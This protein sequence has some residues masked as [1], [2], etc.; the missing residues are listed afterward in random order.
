V[1]YSV[2]IPALDE[3]RLVAAAVASVLR[4]G[5][6]EVIVVDGASD[7]DTCA[8]AARAGARVV[9]SRAGRGIQL[10]HGA[11][12]AT[13][14]WL[15]FLHADTR[16]EAGWEQ[17]LERL[18]A[19]V[20]GGA[21][22]LAVDSRRWRYRLVEAGV[23]ARCRLFRTP[24]GDQGIFVRRHLYA[25]CGGFPPWPLMED[26]VFVRRLR[27]LGRLAFPT[28]RAFTSPRRAESGGFVAT[29]LQNWWLMALFA[30]GRSPVDLAKRYRR[31]P[32]AG[33]NEPQPP[34]SRR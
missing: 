3:Q 19:D 15:V 11:R 21:F 30:C 6:T 32:A 2:V 18:P 5:A 8:V 10:D 20:V 4:P 31:A 22:R 23:A 34:I 9:R 1:R 12:C 33:I 24:Y 29:N 16:L 28:Q 14:D 7:D 25:R 17:S 26:V 13:G 27:C